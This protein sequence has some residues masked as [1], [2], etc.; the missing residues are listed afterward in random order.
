MNK[1]GLKEP[2]F[3]NWTTFSK[4]ATEP[5][6]LLHVCFQK[7]ALVNI[8]QSRTVKQVLQSSLKINN[9]GEKSHLYDKCFENRT[10]FSS[11]QRVQVE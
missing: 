8:S 3:E 11:F 1:L 7:F 5:Q 4:K 6:K 2:G 9:V 10:N